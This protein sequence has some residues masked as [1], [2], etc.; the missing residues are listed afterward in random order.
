M[1][2]L[3]PQSNYSYKMTMLHTTILFETQEAG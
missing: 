1:S 2:P 3:M